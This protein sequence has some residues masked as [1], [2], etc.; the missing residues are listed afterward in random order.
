LRECGS[1]QHSNLGERNLSE[2]DGAAEARGDLGRPSSVIANR[3]CSAATGAIIEF[4]ERPSRP[5]FIKELS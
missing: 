4:P 3:S 2:G 5:A 1:D